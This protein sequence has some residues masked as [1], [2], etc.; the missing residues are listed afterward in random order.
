MLHRRFGV[1]HQLQLQLIDLIRLDYLEML[2][3]PS[4]LGIGPWWRRE[5]FDVVDPEFLYAH[6]RRSYRSNCDIWNR[7]ESYETKD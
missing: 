5:S 6:D 2:K 4:C 7:H 1:C 3:L